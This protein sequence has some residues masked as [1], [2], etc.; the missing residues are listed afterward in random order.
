MTEAL[1]E[2]LRSEIMATEWSALV[3]HF[4]RGAL[5]L[6]HPDTDLLDVSV[7]VARDELTT[8]Q[9]WLSQGKLWRTRD[10]DARAFNEQR[11]RFQFVIVQPWVL[12]QPLPAPEE[13]RAR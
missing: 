6:V 5:F 9:A 7:A 8:V 3:P 1:R 10:A 12:A 13:P 2:K 4:A 11:P